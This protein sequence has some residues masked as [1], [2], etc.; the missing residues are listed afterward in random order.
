MARDGVAFAFDVSIDRVECRGSDRLVRFTI[1]AEEHEI[2]VDE[3]LVGV[4]RAP[5]VEGLGLEAA[6]VAFDKSGVTVNPKLQTSNPR[7][8]A[9]GDIC[10]PFKFTHTADAMAQ[11]VI[12]NALFPHPFGLGMASTDS[13][14]I[15]WC[16][17]TEPEIAHVGMYAADATAKGIE[18]E[19]FTQTFDE[20][21]RAIL[22]G[23]DEGL[24]RV[25]V[26][27]G[28]DE[29]LGATI[30]G[31][32]AGNAIS[33]VTVAMKAKARPGCDRGRDSPLPHTGRGVAEG[34]EPAAPGP[35]LGATEGAANPSVRRGE[36]R[37]DDS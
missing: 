2:A 31:G 6:G 17:Y 4:G 8:Y 20:V 24:A 10:F 32:D 13:L 36:D 34:G 12:Q 33:E 15:P 25:H 3:I 16:T 5:N 11:I 22:D 35:V 14:I 9:A 27:R 29:I 30:V 18:V 7:I 26:K 19:T 28:T 1:N 37:R 21:D 23:E